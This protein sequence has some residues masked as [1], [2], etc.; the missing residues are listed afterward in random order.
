MSSDFYERLD[1]RVRELE[2]TVRGLRAELDSTRAIAAADAAAAAPPPPVTP[3]PATPPPVTLPAPAAAAVPPSRASAPQYYDQLFGPTF[4]EDVG[5][6]PTAHPAAAR[7]SLE[8]ILAGRGLQIAGL[9]LVLLGTAFFLDMAFT[10]GWI[11]PLERIV[12]GLVTG[13]ALIVIAAR[14]IGPA[15]TFLAEGLIGLGAGILYLSLWASV[16]K[17]PQLHVSR[18]AVFF[19]MIAVTAVLGA[20]A[21]TRRSERL[22]LMGMFG[23]FITPL[24]LTSGPPDRVVL[25]AYLLILTAAM[26]WLGVRS[27]FRWVEAI[28]FAAALCYAPAFAVDRSQHWNDVA[29]AVVSTLFFALFAVAFTLGALRD[30]E[31][32]KVRVGLLA[33]NVSAY[34]FALELLFEPKQTV[35]GSMLLALA[36]VLLACTRIP[37]LPRR[38]QLTYGYFGLAAVTLAVPALFH[39]TSLLDV[40]A[41]EAAV[42]VAVGARTDDRRVLLTGAA[43]FAFTG[44]ALLADAASDPVQHTLLNPLALAFAVYLAALG[45]A[46]SRYAASGEV[47]DV[48]RRWR[49]GGLVALNVVALAG[50]SRA[51]IDLLAGPKGFDD[52]GSAA[53]FGLSAIWTLYATVLFGLGLS[54]HRA[55]L[56]WM[57]LALFGCTIFKVFVVDLASLEVTFR[58]LSFIG[59]GIVLVAVSAWYQRAMVR[60]QA[61]EGDG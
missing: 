17:F 9:L 26:L 10:R 48:Q 53:Q 31:A 49:Q 37:A 12:L 20:L 61:A 5:P 24:L 47:T 43:L 59:V 50:L 34:G 35:L 4:V 1:S 41:I 2:N 25:A 57:A 58:I 27:S 8:T 15:Y 11:G 40:F 30:G 38:L 42:L 54:R 36:A 23:G 19:A 28:T 33:S 7:G 6:A 18:P 39:A 45:F 60:Q 51:C 29:S 56:R 52:I 55:L 46:L 14:R 44:V 13:S 32:S 21:S 3:P 16:A 22:A